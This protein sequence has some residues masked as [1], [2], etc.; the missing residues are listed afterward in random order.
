VGPQAG[1]TAN[2]TYTSAGRYTVTV[3]VK[4]TA[5]PANSSTATQTVTVSQP[6]LPPAATLTLTPTSGLS[7]LAVTADASA[8]TDTDATPIAS[9]TFDFGDGTVVGPQASP[10]ANHTYSTTQP[11]Q[12]FQAK[13]TV[14]DTV[15]NSMT[16]APQTVTTYANLISNPGFETNTTGWNASGSGTG[17]TLARVAGGHSGGWAAQLVNGGS[18]NATCLLNDSP[19]VVGTSTAGQYTGSLWVRADTAGATLNLR[20]REYS[21]GGTLINTKTQTAPLTTTWQKVTVTAPV[22]APGSNFDFNA[23]LSAAQAPPGTC[24]YA[25]DAIVYHG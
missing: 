22:T 2:H 21:S 14:T 11:Q 23:Y 4:D 24:F 18:G 8:S 20:F 5:S 25:D 3:T 7:P 15:Q 12:G 16:T 9:Y 19:N 10:T 1:A 6:D 17:V 13:V